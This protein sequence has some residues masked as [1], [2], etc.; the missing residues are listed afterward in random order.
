M[1]RK[2]LADLA[3]TTPATISKYE[4]GHWQVNQAVIDRIREQSGVEI[5]LRVTCDPG[6]KKRWMEI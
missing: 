4:S 2:E 6:P 5:R 1:T 3:G